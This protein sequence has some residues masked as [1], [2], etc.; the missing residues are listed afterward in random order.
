MNMIKVNIGD[1]VELFNG[2]EGHV[3]EIDKSVNQFIFNNQYVIWFHLND[4]KFLNDEDYDKII[5]N[6]HK[7][8]K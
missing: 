7:L 2:T 3:G 5:K 1:R 4:I 6:I 8:E